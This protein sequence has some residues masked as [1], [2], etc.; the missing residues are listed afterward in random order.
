MNVLSS[1][2]TAD[3]AYDIYSGTSMATPAITG[4]SMLLQQYYS[5]LHNTFMRSAT[6]KGLLIHTADEAG[7]YPGPDY[8]YGWG[9]VDIAKAAA[10]ITSVWN[11]VGSTPANPSGNSSTM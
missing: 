4:S 7:P 9:L 5:Q 10:V 8:M 1:I 11:G 3:D 2:S 6:L